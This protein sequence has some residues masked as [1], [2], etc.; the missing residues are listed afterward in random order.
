MKEVATHS[1]FA[2][3]LL[4]SISLLS[5]GSVLA[6]ENTLAAFL[7]ARRV[8]QTKAVKGGKAEGT[9]QGQS[10]T[11]QLKI[12]LTGADKKVPVHGLVRITDLAQ[13]KSLPL[14]DLIKRE[15]DWYV[16]TGEDTVSVPQTDLAP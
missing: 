1:H 8:E 12:K 14:T 6:H 15:S 11:C 10:E 4:L 9:D 13:G 7:K 5:S 3:C 2:A 16:A